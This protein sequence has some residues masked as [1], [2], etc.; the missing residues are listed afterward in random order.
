M[1]INRTKRS[2]ESISSLVEESSWYEMLWKKM[3]SKIVHLDLMYVNILRSRLSDTKIFIIIVDV[4]ILR[5]VSPSLW[6]AISSVSLISLNSFNLKN[7]RSIWNSRSILLMTVIITKWL[8]GSIGSIK[9]KTGSSKNK[10][11]S[12]IKTK[13]SKKGFVKISNNIL[14]RRTNTSNRKYLKETSFLKKKTKGNSPNSKSGQKKTHL[15]K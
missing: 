5:F 1:S 13:V 8:I 14:C 11:T 15:T 6:I 7:S 2:T 4:F 3:K 12:S 9:P 10:N